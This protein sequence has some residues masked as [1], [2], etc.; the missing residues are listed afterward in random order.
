MKITAGILDLIFPP[1][2]VCPLC[3]GFQ[4]R[5]QVCGGCLEKMLEYRSEPVCFICG[6]YFQHPPA[7]ETS[8]L[9]GTGEGPAQVYC[10]DCLKGRHFFS[11]ARAAGPYEDNIRRAVKRL[12][13]SG[14]KNLAVYLSDMMLRRVAGIRLYE[15]AEIMAA[16]PLSPGRLRERGFNQAELLAHNLALK[17]GIPFLPVLRK[18]RETPAQTGLDRSGREENLRGAF[19]LTAPDIVN[20]RKI[21]VVDDVITT[22]ST[23]NT[24][25][26]VLAGGGAASV[27]CLT[28]AAGRTIP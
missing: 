25:A 10:K 20:G 18:V 8:A 28:V 15:G 7:V 11:M 27:V 14:K 6:R 2:R 12:K 13:F 1:R 22:G 4:E 5:G 21:I 24:V 17:M 3:G 23:L 19:I 26:G 16:V 9:R